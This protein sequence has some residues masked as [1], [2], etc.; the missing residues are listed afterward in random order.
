MARRYIQSRSL[1]GLSEV[2]AKFGQDAPA[3]LRSVGLNP[4]SMR[5]R[6]VPI[7]FSR[8]CELL[9]Y[10]ADHWKVPDLAFR[11][12][13]FQHLEILGPVALVTRMERNLRDALRAILRNLV[14]YTNILIVSLEEQGDTAALVLS[15]RIEG[16]A[17][18]QYRF[19]ALAVTKNVLEQAAGAPIAFVE[20]SF[21]EAAQDTARAAEAWFGCPVRFDAARTALYFDRAVLDRAI[22][23]E[24][25]AY[26]SIIRR[27][28][29]IARDEAGLS[30][31]EAARDEIA[32]RMELSDCT[33]ESVADAM[34]M[35]PRGLQRRLR[36]EGTSFRE[37][38]DDWR[39]DRA[40]SLVTMTRMP[41]SDVADAL[42]Y[43]HQAVF[44]RAF[45]RWHGI[46]PL[47]C[48]RR[49]VEADRQS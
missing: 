25:V 28:L 6:D 8:Y 41:L 15:A 48:R 30:V 37:L 2:A 21:S 13:P 22:E 46:A 14:V 5:D 7:D 16:T 26:H 38:V 17:I 31:S 24:D 45:S 11:M 49:A 34:R 10:C 4:K 12:A 32:R 19:L 39:R 36:A 23:R 44:T 18:R 29:S 27:Y 42:G 47:A 33:L 40:M 9:E 3:A 35:A 43:A 1:T 20:A